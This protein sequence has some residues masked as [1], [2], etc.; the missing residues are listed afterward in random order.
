MGRPRKNNLT[1]NISGLVD[2]MKNSHPE[3]INMIDEVVNTINKKIDGNIIT[4]KINDYYVDDHNNIW[5]KNFEL[6]GVYNNDKM[7]YYT[8]IKLITNKIV[9]SK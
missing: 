7:H 6:V 5:N 9:N 2:K 4:T 3:H 1:D 8:D